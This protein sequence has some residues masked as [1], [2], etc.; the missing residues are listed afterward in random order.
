MR[1]FYFCN[2]ES[3]FFIKQS[4]RQAAVKMPMNGKKITDQH[5]NDSKI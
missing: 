1:K 4:K 2:E 5:L 3:G